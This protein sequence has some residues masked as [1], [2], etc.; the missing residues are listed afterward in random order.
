MRTRKYPPRNAETGEVKKL[1][2]KNFGGLSR[3]PFV[4]YAD[5][6]DLLSPMCKLKGDT[7]LIQK[8]NA[9]SWGFY[10]L[11]P[12]GKRRYCDFFPPNPTEGFVRGL[13][14]LADE[15]FE[16]YWEPVVKTD[17]T[18][19]EE[20]RLSLEEIINNKDIDYICRY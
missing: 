6:E 19:D 2:F 10:F 11:G 4:C 14:N 20:R 17:L 16:E 12:D 8:H 13:V 1:K 9:S 7:K 3:C 15:R 18:A 5:S